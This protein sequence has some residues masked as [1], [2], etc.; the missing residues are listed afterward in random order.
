MTAATRHARIRCRVQAGVGGAMSMPAVQSMPAA[1]DLRR[2]LGGREFVLHYQPRIDLVSGLGVGAEAL[3]RWARPKRGLVFPGKILPAAQAYG[4]M[5]PIGHWVL[6]EA[7]A[8]AGR[9][10]AAGLPLDS[11]AVNIS[12]PEL[13]QEG[14][15]RT[16]NRILTETGLEPHRLLLEVA[17]SALMH[18][19]EACA[20][21][22]R[23]LGKAGVQLAVDDVGAGL[24]C[25]GHLGRV[26]V[27]MLK[28]DRS[29]VGD[30]ALVAGAG[31]WINA[32]VGAGHRLQRKV[33]AG[34]VESRAQI[35]CLREMHCDEGQ[36]HYFSPPLEAWRFAALLEITMPAAVARD[37][38]GLFL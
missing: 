14:F 7:C 16:V 38:A 37:A 22:L 25:L 18:D 27:D 26:P 13:R 20:R 30:V 1:A 5:V 8:Q 17:E 10:I 29:L 34:G 31:A 4:L 36:G 23:E 24:S 19:I 32:V 33:V 12:G 2:A 21:T 11:M 35:D 28:I 3:L 15:A 6:R 9:W